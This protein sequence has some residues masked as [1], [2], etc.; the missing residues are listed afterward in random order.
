VR[1]EQKIFKLAQNFIGRTD[2]D[3]RLVKTM[4]PQAKY[5]H[6]EEVMRKGFHDHTWTPVKNNQKFVIV[7][8]FRDNLY[9]GLEVAMSACIKLAPLLG[10]PLEWR[11]IGVPEKSQYARVCNRIAGR[12]SASGVKLLGTMPAE[13]IIDELKGADVFVHPSHIDNSP[14]SLCEAMMIGLPIVSTNVGG[15]PSLLEDKTEGLLVQNGDAYAMAG[16]VLQLLQ[17][18]DLATALA[19]NARQRA[20]KRHDRKKIIADLQEIYKQVM[21]TDAVERSRAHG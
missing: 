16:A 4:A 19:K 17:N 2:W 21:S 6:C 5:H 8:T 13:Q 12:T 10:K 15:I 14:N 3:S 20:L 18:P 11:I 7:S 9:K 1:R